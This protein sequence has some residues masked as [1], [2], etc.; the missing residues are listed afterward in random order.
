MDF[1]PDGSALVAQRLTGQVVRIRTGQQPEPVVTISGV[2]PVSEGGL[3]GLAVSPSYAQDGWIYVYFTTASDNR[4]A[5]VPARRAA[6]PAA[7]PHRAEPG[8]NPQ[9]RPDR[10]RSGRDALRSPAT[11]SSWRACAASGC[12]MCRSTDSGESAPRLRNWSAATGGCAPRRPRLRRPRLRRPRLRRPRLDRPHARSPAWTANQWNTGFTAD[13]RV[14]NRGPALTT[15]AL[16]WSFSGNQQV[17]NGWNAQVTQSGRSVTARNASWN[18]SLPTN[19]TVSVGLQATYAGTNDRLTD[20]HLNG[21]SC[22][23][24]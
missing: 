10:L 14:T 4:I 11:D 6:D 18:G 12:G 20:F 17:T 16:T 22:Q 13:V 1:L 2:T 9:W 8:G 3:L 19:G 24:G 23:P 5:P 7:D 15:W 21:A